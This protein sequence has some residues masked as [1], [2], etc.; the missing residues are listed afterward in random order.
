MLKYNG[1][2]VAHVFFDGLDVDIVN[3]N[4]VKVFEAVRKREYDPILM[5][6]T[7]TP[8]G[9]DAVM[10]ITDIQEGGHIDAPN[11]I[12]SGAIPISNISINGNRLSFKASACDKGVTGKIK[13]P[14]VECDEYFD[15]LIPIE[16][17]S[18][19]HPSNKLTY[20]SG[21]SAT[22]T[23]SGYS[24]YYTCS[25]DAANHTLNSSGNEISTYIAPLGHNFT[26]QSTTSTYLRS[27][28]NCT[29]AATYYYKCSR[30]TEKGSSYYTYGSALGHS[31]S[32]EK[33]YS[34]SRQLRTAATCTAA[35][36]YWRECDRCTTHS[37]TQYFTY[38][39]ALGHNYVN[40]KCTRC[41][42]IIKVKIN[43]MTP[44]SSKTVPTGSIVHFSISAA[45]Y[46]LS[47]LWYYKTIGEDS[48]F[49][50]YYAKQAE[51]DYT[52]HKYYAPQGIS[53]YCVVTDG[54]GNTATSN[55]V[56]IT[57]Q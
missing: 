47:Y 45:G 4:G 40:Y 54:Y 8:Y 41:G 10:D 9:E 34:E 37:N 12:S 20:H 28:A 36:T 52:H 23:G 1:T 30:C 13:I 2:E 27:A 33:L 39:N 7:V 18:C 31:F 57:P 25:C 21:S 42:D 24:S 49:K 46:N 50:T 53:W 11:I 16:L 15:Y 32:S 22:C 3:I 17:D 48:S 38:G 14:V 6:K 5:T 26:S 51:F 55:T 19:T 56:T 29:S 43:S 44:S 35:A